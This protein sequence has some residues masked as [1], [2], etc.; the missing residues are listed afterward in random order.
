MQFT[1]S[2][3]TPVG[4]LWRRQTA[5]GT[6][7]AG[8][9][10]WNNKHSTTYYFVFIIIIIVHAPHVNCSSSHHNRYQNNRIFLHTQSTWLYLTPVGDHNSRH[11]NNRIFPRSL[12]DR[13]WPQFDLWQICRTETDGR[14]SECR[15]VG[16]PRPGRADVTRACALRDSLRRRTG[17]TADA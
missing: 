17:E 6:A 10:A 11:Q 4:D 7:S 1:W 12:P 2:Y 8:W 15:R 9:W 3:L 5:G 13:T 16:V 14:Y